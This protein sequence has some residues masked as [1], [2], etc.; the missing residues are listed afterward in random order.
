[1]STL[2]VWKFNT[3]DG[4]ENALTKLGDLQ[5]QQIVQVLDAAIV[6]QPQGRKSP[7]TNQAF[8]TVG[9]GALGGAFWGMLFGLLFFAP[10]LGVIV[11]ATAGAISGKFTDYGISDSFIQDVQSK[12]TEGTSALFLLT[13]QVTVDK[14]SAAFAPEEKGE[15]IQSNLSTE[16]ETKLREDFGSEV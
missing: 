9:A 3:V 2:T 10:L 11:G 7:K 15:L 16:Q 5:K 14:V 1:M 12:V 8:N 13:G 6:S 4:A